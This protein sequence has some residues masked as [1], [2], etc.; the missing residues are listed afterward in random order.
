[1][2][3]KIFSLTMHGRGVVE[4]PKKVGVG[5][6]GEGV[7]ASET[8]CV[9]WGRVKR[10]VGG[11]QLASLNPTGQLK[12]SNSMPETMDAMNC[13]YRP[14]VVHWGWVKRRGQ[15]LLKRKPYCPEKNK[16]N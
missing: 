11:F 8:D 1:M 3:S 10:G 14:F 16:K 2:E 6:V 12:I 9:G 7:M 15:T 13:C 4:G 5:G